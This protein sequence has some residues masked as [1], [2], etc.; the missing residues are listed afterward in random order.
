MDTAVTFF[1]LVKIP[2]TIIHVISV[3]I[4]MG[5]ALVSDILF[6]F[7]AKDKKLNMTEQKTLEILSRVVWVSLAIISISGIVIFFSDP[8][9]YMESSKFLAK[10]SILI[11]LVVNG[12]VLN[13]SVWKHLLRPG[14]FTSKKESTFRKVA[15]TGGAISV[16]SWLSVCALGV[17]DSSP[18]GYKTLMI[19]YFC[20]ITVGVVCSLYVE[21]RKFEQKA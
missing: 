7:F 6:T 2:A 13:L 3:V 18:V 1:S 12:I 21:S 4:G 9:R 5:A 8:A 14:F 17:L 20:L 16:I 15:F 11:V 19:G 10:I